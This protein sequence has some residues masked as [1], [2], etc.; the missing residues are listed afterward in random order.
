[1][2]RSA[3]FSVTAAGAHSSAHNSREEKP[4]YLIGTLPGSENFYDLRYSDS[5]FLELAAAKYKETTGQKMQQKQKDALIKETVLSIEAHHTE[6]DVQKVFDELAAKYGGHYVTELSIHRDEG[7][8]EDE[9]GIT[10]YPTKDIL[11]KEDGWYIVPLAESIT[12]ASDYRP[13]GEEFSEKVDINDFKPI[14]NIHA[15]VKFSM[16]NPDIGKTGRMK[17]NELNDRIKTA[18]R[19]LKLKYEPE[20][21]SDKRGNV[22]E[23]KS[24]HKA[25]RN[26]KVSN[27]LE[28]GGISANIRAKNRQIEQLEYN[29]REAQK[30]ISSLQALDVEQKK[31]LHRL[32]TEINKTADDEVKAQKIAELEKKLTDSTE[33]AIQAQNALLEAQNTIES[34]KGVIERLKAQNAE[35]D[36]SVTDIAVQVGVLPPET[37]TFS[38]GLVAPKIANAV[39]QLTVKAKEETDQLVDMIAELHSAIDHQDSD[40]LKIAHRQRETLSYKRSTKEPYKTAVERRNEV[41]KGRLEQNRPKQYAAA[42]PHKTDVQEA[43]AEIERYNAQHLNKELT[44]KDPC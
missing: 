35:K 9:N 25:V 15:H 40:L 4:K 38:A 27:F 39:E 30:R 19:V 3:T 36:K 14:H 44:I 2:P 22:T 34:Q 7:H 11:K 24:K 17:H 41:Y 37:P 10:Y 18:A 8:F 43:L 21:K 26:E 29:F 23:V 31:E 20:K 32:N 1:M 28:S 5:D 33:I 12:H 13:K 42:A 16:F 6:A